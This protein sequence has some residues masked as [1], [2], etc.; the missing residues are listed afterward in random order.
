MQDA[1]LINRRFLI[2]GMVALAACQTATNPNL[3][4]NAEQNFVPV[5]NAAALMAILGGR[6]VEYT[7]QSNRGA[8]IKQTFNR[9]GTTQYGDQR[10][11][12][13]V[14]GGRYCSTAQMD[15]LRT[16]WECFQFDVNEAGTVLRWRRSSDAQQLS[17]AG[18]QV[19]TWYGRIR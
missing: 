6:T 2:L 17:A 13:S 10:R 15:V 9:D 7:T 1:V 18:G 16:D 4:A 11:L 19:D 3:S 14:E 12:W 5:E 8:G